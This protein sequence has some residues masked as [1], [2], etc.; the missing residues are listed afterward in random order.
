ML[1]LNKILVVLNLLGAFVFMVLFSTDNLRRAEWNRA[2]EVGRLVNKGLP[3]DDKDTG[4]DKDADPL[5]N[6]VDDKVQKALKLDANVKTQEAAVKE[7]K[8]RV[9]G[10][11]DAVASDPRK[12]LAESARFLL[13]LANSYGARERLLV[14]RSYQ[15]PDPVNKRLVDQLEQALTLT[16]KNLGA[17]ESDE[18]AGEA[19][20]R[21]FSKAMQLLSPGEGKRQLGDAFV[22]ALTAKAGGQSQLGK[23]ALAASKAGG[24][25]AVAV[26][27]RTARSADAGQSQAALLEDTFFEADNQLL[28][29]Q[30]AGAIRPALDSLRNVA[31][32]PG[33]VPE[34]PFF[35]LDR[36]KGEIREL[37]PAIEDPLEKEARAKREN[38]VAWVKAAVVDYPGASD[39]DIQRVIAFRVAYLKAIAEQPG[40]PKDP[41]ALAFFDQLAADP[42]R[43]KA[44]FEAAQK[45]WPASAPGQP[46]A[47]A[48]EDTAVAFVKKLLGSDEPVKPGETVEALLAPVVNEVL[49]KLGTELRGELNQEFELALNPNA[50]PNRLVFGAKED[51]AQRKPASPS[52]VQRPTIA[53]LL[54]SLTDV[55]TEASS[56]WQ[57]AAP[58]AAAASSDL[59]EPMKKA[60]RVIGLSA[61]A[62]EL[63]RQAD[64]LKQMPEQIRQRLS[65]EREGYL[66][67][68]LLLERQVKNAA[69][70]AQKEQAEV[71]RYEAFIKAR[72]EIVGKPGQMTGRYSD[73]EAFQ[74][75]LAEEQK[76]TQARLAQLEAMSKALFEIRKEVR[77][78]IQLTQQ[79]ED[80]IRYLEMR[81]R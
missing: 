68:H 55:P 73:V 33:E 15:A 2:T 44:A 71:A 47:L 81:R 52:V 41:Y 26:F 22:A 14:L 45:A 49:V 51:D 31:Y 75:R 70:A 59:S 11:L 39:P 18:K 24:D 65:R 4:D 74:Q 66:L 63:N 34:K 60:I 38:A 29:A 69:V 10:R 21:E 53:R 19:F 56:P 1:L 58:D 30:L 20:A 16:L 42:A 3:L 78:A 40:E 35:S 27:L 72:N 46:P 13:P 50:A 43:V 6:R 25:D 64:V 77:D 48:S 7:L 79:Y 23:A 32:A 67:A 76:V 61:A 12:L 28:V 80:G 5:V 36:I 57:P 17:P 37:V 9:N 54:L 62:T 8:N